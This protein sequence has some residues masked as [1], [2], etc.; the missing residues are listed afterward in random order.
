MAITDAR[1]SGNRV[2]VKYGSYSTSFDGVLIGYTANAVF[3][4]TN[5]NLHIHVVK[6]SSLVNS[7]ANITIASNEE[8]MMYGNNVGIKNG[9]NIRMYDENGKPAGTKII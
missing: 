4:K 1:Q 5:R 3:I 7:G 2:S 6:G 9:R 8:V